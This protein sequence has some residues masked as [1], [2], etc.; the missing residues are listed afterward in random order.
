MLILVEVLRTGCLSAQMD[1]IV[2]DEGYLHDIA[3]VLEAQLR[4]DGLVPKE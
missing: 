1:C 3:A 2:E 4:E